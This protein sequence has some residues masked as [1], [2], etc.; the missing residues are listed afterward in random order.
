MYLGMYLCVNDKTMLNSRNRRGES[1]LHLASHHGN[2]RCVR[3]LLRQVASVTSVN[4]MGQ[5]AL[6][7]AVMAGM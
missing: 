4:V 3:L 7:Y 6:H 1:P 2:I 5:I